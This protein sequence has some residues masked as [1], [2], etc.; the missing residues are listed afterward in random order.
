MRKLY[1]RP[2]MRIMKDDDPYLDRWFLTSKTHDRHQARRWMPGLL[3]HH[4]HRPDVDRFP[5]DHPWWFLGI[6]L[7]GGYLE[8]RYDNTGIFTHQV[9]RR[10]FS[11]GFRRASSLHDIAELHGDTWTLILVGP[12]RRKWGFMTDQGWLP[13]ED[14]VEP[15]E[16]VNG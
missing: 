9:K 3:L 7:N 10:R 16:I 15:S 8:S 12:K 4:I 5:H 1:D 2:F 6:V 13:W 11:M 14:Y